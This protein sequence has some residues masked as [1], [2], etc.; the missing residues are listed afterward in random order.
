MRKLFC[1]YGYGVEA[2]KEGIAV[3]ILAGLIMFLSAGSTGIFAHGGEEE[4]APTVKTRGTEEVRTVRIDDF[5]V[6][7]KNPPVEPDTAGTAKIFLTRFATNEPV[8]NAKV[9]L[10]IEGAN[11][12]SQDIEGG[13]TGSPG[14]FTVKL[15]PM[16]QGSAR[17]SIRVEAAGTTDNGS[18]GN[19][20]IARDE[21]DASGGTSATWG[22]GRIALM[23][24]IFALVLALFGGLLYFVWRFAGESEPSREETVSA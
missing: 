15:P 22:W 11:N 9:W 21:A 14:T 10:T 19:I 5:E 6:M 23:T 1:N 13:P 20:T 2:M 17:F 24:F 8:T 12:Q 16:P 4:A 3:S 18:F 7:L